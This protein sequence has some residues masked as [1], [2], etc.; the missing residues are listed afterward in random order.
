MTVPISPIN[1]ALTSVTSSSTRPVPL[2]GLAN[3]GPLPKA[4][5]EVVPGATGFSLHAPSASAMVRAVVMFR[6]LYMFYFSFVHPDGRLGHASLRASSM[7]IVATSGPNHLSLSKQ[8]FRRIPNEHGGRYWRTAEHGARDQCDS[9]CRAA[10]AWSTSGR[11]SGSQFFQSAMNLVYWAAAA[12]YAHSPCSPE[13]CRRS[14]D[15]CSDGSG[16]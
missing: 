12:P 16:R 15:L 13:W 5:I 2:T 6:N 8:C 9:F 14:G 1:G 7:E 10:L 3:A 4:E 11:N